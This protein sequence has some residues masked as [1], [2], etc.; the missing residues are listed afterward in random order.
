[1]ILFLYWA[2]TRLDECR[3][4][5]R[6]CVCRGPPES[7]LLESCFPPAEYIMSPLTGVWALMPASQLKSNT[8]KPARYDR[9]SQLAAQPLVKPSL[10]TSTLPLAQSLQ[11]QTN[12]VEGKKGKQGVCFCKA[13]VVTFISPGFFTPT[14]PPHPWWELLWWEF[15]GTIWGAG[16]AQPMLMLHAAPMLSSLCCKRSASPAWSK[17]SGK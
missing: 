3:V 17:S 10:T 15:A 4:A 1:M 2:L 5:Q 7:W 11:T 14:T 13:P 9:T 6:V 8:G 16:V 12:H